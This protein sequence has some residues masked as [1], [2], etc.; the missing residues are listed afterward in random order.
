VPAVTGRR[1][2]SRRAGAIIE[3]TKGS[4]C[5]ARQVALACCFLFPRSDRNC[6][7]STKCKHSRQQRPTRSQLPL[8]ETDIKKDK[9]GL[10]LFSGQASPC[11]RRPF[12][13]PLQQA[14]GCKASAL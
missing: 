14:I 1:R 2:R 6:L 10:T 7:S 12:H 13:T 5:L 9:T 8:S 11:R 4:C 3:K